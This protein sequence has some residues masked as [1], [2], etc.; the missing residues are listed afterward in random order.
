MAA[1]VSDAVQAMHA[2][3]EDIHIDYKYSAADQSGRFA[4][5][6]VQTD[7]Q[8]LTSSHPV[9]LSHTITDNVPSPSMARPAHPLM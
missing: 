4:I 1:D 2:L 8:L 9:V 3:F 5:Y 7:N 6:S